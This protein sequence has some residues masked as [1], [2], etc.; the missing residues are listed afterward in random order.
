MKNNQWFDQA[1]RK[2]ADRKFKTAL[3]DLRRASVFEPTDHRPY[4]N[5]LMA[6][7]KAGVPVNLPRW[8]NRLTRLVPT[9]FA[10]VRSLL[11]LAHKENYPQIL[12]CLA[13]RALIMSPD[14]GAATEILINSRAKNSSKRRKSVLL[15]AALSFGDQTPEIVGLRVDE[16]LAENQPEQALRLLQ[17][18]QGR[19]SDADAKY[20]NCLY[21]LGKINEARQQLGSRISSGL[22]TTNELYAAFGEERAL[23]NSDKAIR[24]AKIGLCNIPYDAHFHGLLSSIYP[25][26]K[27]HDT[28]IKHIIRAEISNPEAKLILAMA[29]GI[30]YLAQEN[31]PESARALKAAT[32]SAPGDA[33]NYSNL[34][35][36]RSKVAQMREGE[37]F[38]KRALMIKADLTEA[39][40]N[41]AIVCRF[42][43]RMEDG[44]RYADLAMKQN[45][46][47]PM[48][49]FTKGLINLSD[50]DARA[51]A[52]DYDARWDV[53]SFAS[54][55]KVRPS[56]SLKL[57]L[58]EGQT[59]ND[60]DLAIWG[61]QGVGDEL[62]YSS[63]LPFA[64][65]RVGN[66][67]FECTPHLAELFRR[68]FPNVKIVPRPSDPLTNLFPGASHQSPIGNIFTSSVKSGNYY[69]GG[70][71]KPDPELVDSYRD[72]FRKK[73]PKLVVGISWI[74]RKGTSYRSFRMP[75]SNWSSIFS[76][77]DIQFVDLQYGNTEEERNFAANRFDVDI[78][79]DEN[80]DHFRDLQSVAAQV[81]AV[82]LV[83]TVAN[84][85]VPLA[86]GVNVP[87]AVALRTTQE[88]W[89]FS[90][91][92]A[93][94][95]WFSNVTPFWQ[96]RPFHW[97]GVLERVANWIQQNY[98]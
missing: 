25:Q 95:R 12:E 7:S 20:I 23:R 90:R 34:G 45:A 36:L 73:N 6:R 27:S 38:L 62:W 76:L 81:A 72:R 31:Y 50:G 65:E 92:S 29:K 40:G 4:T 13:V 16:L 10:V 46:D 57:P 21:R 66:C 96:T 43:N 87:A 49:R 70:H 2:L 37:A 69:P 47:E 59:S 86:Y 24:F 32:V 41:L 89:R 98:F 51:G 28:A 9:N 14:Y 52:L 79:R 74:S 91:L 64:L 93:E 97:D 39:F 82:D 22:F 11:L 15:G 84:S 3:N 61:E 60:I 77:P 94:Q 17:R 63:Y 83:V 8:Y 71:L 67:T 19:L 80:V 75:L 5:D 58:W 30:A 78:D 54:P 48:F 44:I 1:M 26:I 42:Q 56:S 85:T 18:N 35:A 33:L 68:S 53:D 55:R 88:D